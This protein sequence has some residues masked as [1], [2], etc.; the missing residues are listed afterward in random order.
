MERFAVI[1]LGRYGERLARLLA[2]AGAEVIAVDQ[3]KALVENV[4]DIVSL[5]VCLD[6]T[7]EKA[8][9]SQ[10]IDRVSVAIVAIGTAFEASALTTIVLKNLGIPR[11]VAR[12]TTDRRAQILSQIGADD[13]VRPESESAERW[14]DRLLAPAIV[15]RSA[16]GEGYSL[17]QVVAPETFHGKTISELDIGKQYKVLVVAIRR[18]Y[19]EETE[20]GEPVQR[21]YTITAPRPDDVIKPGDV[22]AIIGADEAIEAFPT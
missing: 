5:A 8:L 1:G 20:G 11:V 22:L 4:R 13:I 16:L 14:R 15:E 18:T 6:S 7:D 12:A 21:E 2:E 9:R 19:K 3:Q 10:G 17:A